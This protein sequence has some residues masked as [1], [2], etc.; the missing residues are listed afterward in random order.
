LKETSFAVCP[1]NRMP[2]R[3]GFFPQLHTS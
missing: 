1:G 3:E 2:A